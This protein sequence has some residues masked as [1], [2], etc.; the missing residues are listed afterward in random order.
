L[1]ASFIEKVKFTGIG[2]LDLRYNALKKEFVIIE[3]N[4]RYW[5]TLIGSLLVGKINFPF[6]HASY[7]QSN[8]PHKIPAFKSGVFLTAT[9][10]FRHKKNNLKIPFDE[11]MIHFKN[12]GAYVQLTDPMYFTMGYLKRIK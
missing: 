10:Y 9:A 8:Q 4:N 7:S 2:H 12:S 11:Q 3:I 6:Y 1:V 5:D